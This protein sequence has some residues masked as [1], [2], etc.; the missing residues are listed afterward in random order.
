MKHIIKPSL[1]ISSFLL[2][3]SLQASIDEKSILSEYK[4]ENYQ[5]TIDMS[6]EFLKTDPEHIKVNLLL[7]NSA[8]VLREFHLAM[9]AYDRVLI[10]EPNNVYAKIQ[11]AHIYNLTNNKELLALELDSLEALSLTQEEQETVKRLKENLSSKP[12]ITT[13]LEDKTFGGIVS[14]GLLFDSNADN[15]IGN[16]SF[17]VP[18]LDIALRGSKEESDGAHFESIH[19]YGSF[20]GDNSLGAKGSITLYNKDY[21]DKDNSHNDLMY[22]GLK[23][24]PTFTT[25]EFQLALPLTIQKILLDYK[26]YLTTYGVG[27]ALSRYFEWGALDTGIEYRANRY[28]GDGGNAKDS[29]EGRFYVGAKKITK[30]Y[31]LYGGLDYSIVKAKKELRSDISHSRYGVNL[32]A[33]KKLISNLFGRV[34]LGLHKY[35]YKDL[36]THFLNKRDDTVFKI[37]SG[38][39]YM[40]NENSSVG[41]GVDYFNKNSNQALYDY[42]KLI[43]SAYWAYRF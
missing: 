13:A 37:S 40:F 8:Y 5:S 16:R 11:V 20:Q 28:S 35:S 33:T 30:E 31:Q 32:G 2:A 36:N 7:G 19:L 14:I 23:A 21:F 3:T 42:D 39:D 10:M 43:V 17:H 27:V 15:D 4:N 9:A 6:K 25:Q 22:L 26:S 24:G 41:L 1:L 38:I 12:T 29:D 18:S 34:G